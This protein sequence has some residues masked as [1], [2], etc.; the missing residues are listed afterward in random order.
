M[1]DLFG[2]NS[3]PPSEYF[4]DEQK[5][6]WY[7]KFVDYANNENLLNGDLN[8]RFC[9]GYDWCCEKCKMEKLSACEDCVDTIIDILKENNVLID[10]LDFDFEKW[11]KIAKEKYKE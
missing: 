4:T 10:Y 8:G 1:K 2:E 5:K 7:K 3:V 11:E 6:T 9:C